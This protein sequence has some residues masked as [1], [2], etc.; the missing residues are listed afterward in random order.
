MKAAL[1]VELKRAFVNKGFLFVMLFGSALAVLAFFTTKAWTFSKYWMEYVNNDPVAVQM[2]DKLG[3]ID[4]PLEVWMP[5]YGAASKYYYLWITI[6]PILCAI[7]YSITYF[8]DRKYGLINQL[9]V[10]MNR[11]NYYIA[12]LVT[13]FVSGGTVAIIPLIVNLLMCMCFLPWGMPLRATNVYPVSDS[14]VFS[15]IF[16]TRPELY[17]IIY[18]VFTYVLFGLINCLALIMTLIEDNRFALM[19][20][21]FVI[22]YAQHVLCSFGFGHGEI[23]LITNANLYNVFDSN[24]LIYIGELVLLLVVDLLILFK[25]KKD[26][27]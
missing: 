10:R 27:L 7:P 21:P 16:Y 19:I 9:I 20:T 4:T 23:S 2:A 5:R 11:R 13:C 24:F 12:K 25:I 26:V 18:L 8:Q 15:E 17:V 1:K 22:Y 3:F 14:N 6:L